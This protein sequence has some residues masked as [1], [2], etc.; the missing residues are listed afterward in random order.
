MIPFLFLAF[1]TSATAHTVSVTIPTVTLTYD[2]EPETV[3]VVSANKPRITEF[4]LTTEKILTGQIPFFTMPAPEE[5]GAPMTTRRPTFEMPIPTLERPGVQTTPTM[6]SFLEKPSFQ[7]IPMMTPTLE[8]PMPALERSGIPA[9]L[10]NPCFQTTVTL[11][12]DHVPMMV[13]TFQTTTV[14]IR[15]EP[16]VQTTSTTTTR[17][18]DI[19]ITPTMTTSFAMPM[20]V[21]ELPAMQT[22]M[23][24]LTLEKPSAQTISIATPTLKE[25]ASQTTPTTTTLKKPSA[26]TIP[27]MT[28]TLRKTERTMMI[29]TGVKNW[30]S[31]TQYL[32]LWQ[33][34]YKSLPCPLETYLRDSLRLGSSS[35]V[36]IKTYNN[37]SYSPPQSFVS[38]VPVPLHVHQVPLLEV[39]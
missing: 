29:V 8:K 37:S 6:T 31:P 10:K 28:P 16:N 7:T 18:L 2:C 21:L 19:P 26:Q 12:M 34:F 27:T 35:N 36:Q 3:T 22:T 24:T 25:H 4:S 20:P 39:I 9:T 23:A 13:A 14:T 17:T 30:K 33:H 38:L 15:E 5:L 32:G 1:V 11:T